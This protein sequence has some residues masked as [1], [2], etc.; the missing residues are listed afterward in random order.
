[1]PLFASVSMTG[2]IV[3]TNESRTTAIPSMD[4]LSRLGTFEPS[5]QT[6]GVSGLVVVTG[7]HSVLIMVRARVQGT[8][9]ATREPAGSDAK[10]G[11]VHVA[12]I[13][14]GSIGGKAIEP[15]H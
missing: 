12:G 15:R 13:V 5:P 8:H 14:N 6:G 2:G 7:W 4:A 3:K 11:A 9:L 1:V 10:T